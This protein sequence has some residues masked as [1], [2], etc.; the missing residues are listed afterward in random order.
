MTETFSQLNYTTPNS[1]RDLT[2][3]STKI[4]VHVKGHGL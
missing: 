2:T 1:I 4:N 3:L